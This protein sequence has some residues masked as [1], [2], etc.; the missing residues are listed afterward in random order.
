MAG[1]KAREEEEEER[2]L[3]EGVTVVDFDMLC[4][5]VA[6]QAQK[7]QWVKLD[8]NGDEDNVGYGGVLRMWEGELFCDSLEDRRIA[9]QSLCC[10]WYRFGKNM[11]RA[12]FGS[13]F[14]QGSIYL[15]LTLVA[16]L[17]MLAFT[18][19]KKRCFLYIG[20][21]F[22]IFVGL[23]MGYHRTKMRNKFNIRGDSS[24]DDCIFHLTCPCCTLSQE[25]RTLEMNNVQDGIWHGRG[26]TICIGSYSELNKTPLELSPPAIVQ[27]YK[28][29]PELATSFFPERKNFIKLAHAHKGRIPNRLSHAML[30]HRMP[31][32]FKEARHF[33]A[34]KRQNASE[35]RASNSKMYCE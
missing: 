24:L 12:G 30:R 4:S 26:D 8:L 13:C 31:A 11:K 32:G 9:I 15:I 17:S 5:T 14:L 18:V 1:E 7:G 16:L 20:G 28:R 21:A 23:Y 10:P 6:R 29:G 33:P 25:A 19:T 34:S 3:S 2:L 22:I 27:A 35:R